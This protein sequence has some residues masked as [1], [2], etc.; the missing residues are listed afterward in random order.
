MKV[1]AKTIPPSGQPGTPNHW[2]RERGGGRGGG[3]GR[4]QPSPLK[5]LAG[6][7]TDQPRSP[8][9]G[10]ALDQLVIDALAQGPPPHQRAG[11]PEEER[12]GPSP[13]PYQG[14]EINMA[15]AIAKVEAMDSVSRAGP[16][17]H[18]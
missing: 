3:G 1:A 8:Q 10:Q 18:Y 17:L 2:I 11:T 6:G 5:T 16:N 15:Q 14:G 4:A 13:S 9:S 7:P 12:R